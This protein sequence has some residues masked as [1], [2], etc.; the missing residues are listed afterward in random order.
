LQASDLQRLAGGPRAA[1][2][3]LESRMDLCGSMWIYI[4]LQGFFFFFFF[5][6][7]LIVVLRNKD[8]SF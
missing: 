1:R 4:Y 8:N 6:F 7:F 5:F 2:A 3:P